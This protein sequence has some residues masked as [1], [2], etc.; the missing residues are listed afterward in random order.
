[1]KTKQQGY[2]AVGLIY[3]IILIAGLVG[4]IWNIIKLVHLVMADGAVTAMFIM[5]ALGT[6]VAPLGA[7]LGY[8]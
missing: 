4:W 3:L 5:R 1:M 6:V 8:L 2:T 7:I